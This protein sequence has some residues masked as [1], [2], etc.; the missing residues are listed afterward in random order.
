MTKLSEIPTNELEKYLFPTSVP[1]ALMKKSVS[2][3]LQKRL[4]RGDTVA[5]KLLKA[6]KSKVVCQQ[7]HEKMKVREM[8]HE[9]AKREAQQRLRDELKIAQLNELEVRK[10]VLSL[11]EQLIELTY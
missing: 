4:E 10:K 11:Q 6:R 8:D 9:V 1:E 2:E 5:G 7:Y 3:E